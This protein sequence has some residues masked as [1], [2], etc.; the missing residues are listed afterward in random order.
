VGTVENIADEYE[1]ARLVVSP[2]LE[3]GG[4]KIKVI[5]ACAYERPIVVTN[6][7]ARG[8]GSE[9]QSTLPTAQSAQEFVELCDGLLINDSK[10]DEVGSNLRVLQQRHFSQDAAEAKIIQ[11]I[12]ESLT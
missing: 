1:T 8:F 3:G 10:C 12:Q 2:I 5:E 7:S 6:H 11:D 9:I 4:S